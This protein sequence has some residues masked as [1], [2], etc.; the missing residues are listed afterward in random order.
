VRQAVVVRAVWAV[1][2]AG[3]VVLAG[4]AAGNR[5]FRN[6]R[7]VDITSPAPL[8]IVS[9]PFDINWRGSAR[10]YAVF[11]DVAPIA[12]GG[13]FRDL[14]DPNCQRDPRCQPGDAYLS[15]LGVYTATGNHVSIPSLG[16]LIGVSAKQPHPLHVATVVVM[17][18]HGRRVGSG[19]WRVEFRA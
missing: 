12:E 4:A 9:T 18:G 7:S 15:R 1:A 19:A 2:L 17:D 13:S 5:T 16:D 6:D 10:R 3:L 14:L 11:V 8:S